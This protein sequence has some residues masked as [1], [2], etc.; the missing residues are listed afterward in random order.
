MISGVLLTV[1][2]RRISKKS[3]CLLWVYGL[4]LLRLKFGDLVKQLQSM[5]NRICYICHEITAVFI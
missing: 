5:L 1:R 4:A 2:A 3:V